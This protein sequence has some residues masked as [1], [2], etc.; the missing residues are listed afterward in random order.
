MKSS[1]DHIRPLDIQISI[2]VESVEQMTLDDIENQGSE[3]YSSIE[4][5]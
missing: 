1:I 5:D 2:G 3:K 4:K